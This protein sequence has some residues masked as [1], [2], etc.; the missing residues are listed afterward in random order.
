MQQDGGTVVHAFVFDVEKNKISILELADRIQIMRL[1]TRVAV[2]TPQ[3]HTMPEAV[4]IMTGAT[5]GELEL[6]LV[7]E[8]GPAQLPTEEDA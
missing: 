8:G 7:T 1:G 2:V 3:T 5:R 6:T 4:A